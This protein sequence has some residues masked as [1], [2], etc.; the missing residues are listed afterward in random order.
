MYP[1]R[2]SL[3]FCKLCPTKITD[4]ER[5]KWF[6]LC[7]SCA[8]EALAAF[9]VLLLADF[10]DAER[11]LLNDCFDGVGLDEPEKARLPE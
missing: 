5:L 10:N 11:K 7:R 4:A 3:L 9:K 2:E 6:G 8:Q 1:A